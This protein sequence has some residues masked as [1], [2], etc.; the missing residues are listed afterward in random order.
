ME[1]GGSIYGESKEVIVDPV[2][3][4]E[5]EEYKKRIKT[6]IGLLEKENKKYAVIMRNVLLGEYHYIESS[7]LSQEKKRA[8]SAFRIIYFKLYKRDEI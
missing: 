4:F 3:D 8:F 7:N 2:N 1:H 5:Q 6:V